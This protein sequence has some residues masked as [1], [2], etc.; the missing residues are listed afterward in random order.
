DLSKQA[1]CEV[2]LGGLAPQDISS[3]Q[4]TLSTG[5]EKP[6][7]AAILKRWGGA[8]PPVA[9]WGGVLAPGGRAA[10]PRGE[11]RRPPAGHDPPGAGEAR[12]PASV[13]HAAGGRARRTWRSEAA[14]G[15]CVRCRAGGSG[16]VPVEDGPGP[17][18]GALAS[19]AG[20]AAAVGRPDD[21]EAGESQRRA[22]R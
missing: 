12:R 5:G 17:A 11:P 4:I 19:V 22:W 3:K 1:K 21:Y 20:A 15:G 14:S 16:S 8:G 13:R 6:V 10:P 2:V 18:V 9:G 7:W